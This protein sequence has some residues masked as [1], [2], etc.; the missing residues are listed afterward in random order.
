MKGKGRADEREPLYVPCTS[1]SLGRQTSKV[2]YVGGSGM[3]ILG[4]DEDDKA[5]LKRMVRS[6]NFTQ[7]TNALDVDRHM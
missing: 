4:R 6:N 3:L 2:E 7:Q 1:S 5:R